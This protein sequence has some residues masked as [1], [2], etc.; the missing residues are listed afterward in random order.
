MFYLGRNL[1]I[2]SRGFGVTEHAWQ[3]RKCGRAFRVRE[4]FTVCYCGPDSGLGAHQVIL[5]VGLRLPEMMK[6]SR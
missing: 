6:I 4:V 1:A 3:V 2:H 5:P